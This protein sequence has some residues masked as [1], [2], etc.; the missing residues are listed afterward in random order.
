MVEGGLG[1]LGDFDLSLLAQ[2]G[3]VRKVGR[4]SLLVFQPPLILANFSVSL[5]SKCSDVFQRGKKMK[6]A[7]KLVVVWIRELSGGRGSLNGDE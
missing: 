3:K 6:G 1:E 5:P 2:Q 7:S 4:E